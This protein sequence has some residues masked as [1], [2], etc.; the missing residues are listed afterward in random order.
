[1]PDT[2]PGA[3]ETDR[4]EKKSKKKSLQWKEVPKKGEIY[5]P[6]FA[7]TAT[8]LDGL[9]YVFGGDTGMFY[10]NVKLLNDLYVY[11]PETQKW[12]HLKPDVNDPVPEP[13]CGH[14]MVAYNQKLIL[15]GGNGRSKSTETS[16]ND[17]WEYTPTPNGNG[18][19]EKVEARGTVP[20]ARFFHTSVVYKDEM[21]VFGGQKGDKDVWRL[22]LKKKEWHKQT[23]NE[24]IDFNDSG[25]PPSARW[26]HTATVWGDHMYT[27]GGECETGAVTSELWK[28]NFLTSRWQLLG[29]TKTG[30]P[31]ASRAHHAAV[32]AK[33]KWIIHAGRG[34]QAGKLGDAHEFDFKTEKWGKV[35]TFMAPFCNSGRWG[36]EIV[37]LPKDKAFL[38]TGGAT[39]E[40]LVLL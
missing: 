8:V 9:V 22:D 6:R 10:T 13:R 31:P 2:A 29:P 17:V 18:K 36:H 4:L 23:R 14:T 35:S 12:T 16:F 21:Y 1:M 5:P 37:Y 39:I 15:F 3:F 40:V 38:V 24:E 27:F 25:S 33:D 19:W 20:V 32:S 30:Q 34:D 7:H 11:K 28:F 26:M